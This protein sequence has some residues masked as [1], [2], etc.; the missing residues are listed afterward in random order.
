[1]IEL[2]LHLGTE[3]PNLLWIAVPSLL[4]FAAGL[5]LGLFAGDRQ[6]ESE[7]DVSPEP[8]K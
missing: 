5:G 6:E 1:M 3:H 7:A 2:P 4:S 8:E